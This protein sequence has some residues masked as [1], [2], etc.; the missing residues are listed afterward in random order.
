MSF[1]FVAIHFEGPLSV[2]Y[3]GFAQSHD[4]ACIWFPSS[5][6]FIGSVVSTLA[7]RPS[8]K[9]CLF[10]E[11]PW[12]QHTCDDLHVLVLHLCAGRREVQTGRTRG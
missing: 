4:F 7:L 9:E 12:A 1:G 5:C 3:V 10:L 2:S 8:V 11:L 6:T